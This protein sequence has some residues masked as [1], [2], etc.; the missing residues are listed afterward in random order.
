MSRKSSP[1]TASAPRRPRNPLAFAPLMR[2]GGPHQ[3]GR[4]GERL[5]GKRETDRLVRKGRSEE[6]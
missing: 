6:D 1:K 4:G 3:R 2:K 5:Q